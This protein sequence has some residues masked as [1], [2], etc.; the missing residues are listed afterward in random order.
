MLLEVEMFLDTH[1]ET[2]KELLARQ[3]TLAPFIMIYA[4]DSWLYFLIP[5]QDNEWRPARWFRMLR[6]LFN[7]DAIVYTAEANMLK[8]PAKKLMPNIPRGYISAHPEREEVLIL[9]VWTKD[10]QQFMSYKI[11]R[12]DT[13]TLELMPAPKEM[14]GDL[15]D[16]GIEERNECNKIGDS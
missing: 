2:C 9:F 15:W 14:G 4:K 13:I 12:N 10:E 16:T 11:K 3:K 8:I 1:I 5:H 6:R 7:A